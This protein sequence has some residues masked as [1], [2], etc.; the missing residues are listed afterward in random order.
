MGPLSNDCCRYKKRKQEGDSPGK[1]EPELGALLTQA[2]EGPGLPEAGKG[3]SPL[4]GSQE[5]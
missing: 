4:Q 2:K 5:V 1:T 3:G